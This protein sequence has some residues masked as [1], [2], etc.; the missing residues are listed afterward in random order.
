MRQSKPLRLWNIIVVVRIEFLIYT[1]FNPSIY[2]ECVFESFGYLIAKTLGLCSCAIDYRIWQDSY[3][4]VSHM[5]SS[6]S[7]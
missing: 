1:L 4:L 2:A 6:N 5:N 3:L 7:T